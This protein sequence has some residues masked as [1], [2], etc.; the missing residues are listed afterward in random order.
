[1]FVTDF[2]DVCWMMVIWCWCII[3]TTVPLPLFY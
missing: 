1:M 3:F 2:A